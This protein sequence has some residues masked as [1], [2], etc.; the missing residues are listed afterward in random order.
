MTYDRRLPSMRSLKK[1]ASW[2][3]PFPMKGSRIVL[4]ARRYGFD[5]D[6]VE[7]LKLFSRD[8]VF[9]SRDDFLKQCQALQT[10]IREER[11]APVEALRSPQD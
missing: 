9:H 10:I 7:F 2:D 6:V 5:D 4:G 8:D 1:L 3:G 11:G